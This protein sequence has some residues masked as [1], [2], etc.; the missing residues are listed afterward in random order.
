MGVVSWGLWAGS[1]GRVKACRLGRGSSKRGSKYGGSAGRPMGMAAYRPGEVAAWDTTTPAV[2]SLA[3]RTRLGAWPAGNG[4]GRPA[5]K[6]S[7]GF[8]AATAA[9]PG[10]GAVRDGRPRG[11]D[12]IHRERQG[13][14][15]VRHP[16]SGSGAVRPLARR[17]DDYTSH[18]DT[19]RMECW[20]VSWI[21]S[22]LRRG[23]P[24]RTH[25]RFT[26]GAE[27]THRPALG[28]VLDGLGRPA[29][30]HQP[31]AVKVSTA[32]GR[33]AAACAAEIERVPCRR[34]FHVEQPARSVSRRNPPAVIDHAPRGT[35]A[36][37]RRL[38][39]QRRRRLE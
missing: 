1:V 37:Q 32:G 31:P 23:L 24:R 38:C 29:D 39:G 2:V 19:G 34:E 27:W 17:N 6:R 26:L 20:V 16:S 35:Y 8:A 22:G 10:A 11:E 9:A 13:P 14:V 30:G 28:P 36:Q 33:P 3:A 7:P 5:Y 15:G 4:R 12:K 21:V 18:P 25:V